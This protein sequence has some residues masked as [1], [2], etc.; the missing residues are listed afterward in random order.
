M[1]TLFKYV[2]KE[3]ILPFFIGLVGFIIFVSVELLY[4]LSDVIVQNHVSFWSLLVLVYYNLPQ[5]VVMGI[6]VGVLLAIF[7]EISN[8]SSRRELM[9]FQVHGINLKKFVL[10]FLVIGIALSFGTYL[11]QDF[12]VPNYNSKAS[13]YLA[14]TVWHSGLPQV[15]TNT[16][17]K[18][19]NS[20]FYVKA[21]DPNTE[22]FEGVLIYKVAGNSYTVTYAK[23]AYLQKGNWFLKDGRIYTLKNGVMT[24]DM[25]FKTMKLKMTQDIVRFIRSQK[26]AQSMSSK[27]LRERIKLFKRLG[28]DPRIYVV[29]L[30]SR[31]ANSIAPLI[32]AFL[33]VPF[34]LFF[35][36][37][38]KSWGVIV[39]F[40]LVVLYQG[41]GAW[42]SAM[43]KNGMFPPAMSAWTPDIIFASLGAAFFL[44]LDSK[45]MFKVK[46]TIVKLLPVF[47][48]F[49][50]VGL[51][52]NGFG[53]QFS[54]SAKELNIV[55]STEVIYSGNVEVKGSG[56]TIE[57]STLKILFDRYGRAKWAI[58]EGDVVF[59][60]KKKKITATR[61][62][63]QLQGYTAILDDIRGVEKVKNAKG[64]KKDVYFYGEHSVYDTKSG[65]SIITPG[66]I[67][68][69]NF[70]P[71]H[72]KI[73]ASK[74]YF[75]PGDHMV[76]YNVVMY[77]F[78]VPIFYLPEYYYSLAG[79]KQPMEI[80][81]NHSASEG[82]Y[83]SVRFNFSPSPNLNA[84]VFFS[85]YEKGPS[86]QS[87]GLNAKIK[88]I[89]FAFSY[90]KTEENGKISS[91]NLKLSASGKFFGY[92]S[93][94]SY[95]ENVLG[96]TRNAALALNGPLAN[97]AL[98]LKI[99]QSVAGNNQKYELPYSLKGLR[100][101]LGK[102]TANSVISGN[103]IF[104]LPSKDFSVANS[105][106][107]K[108]SFP[109]RFLTL[110]SVSGTYKGGLSFSSNAPFS[111]SVFTDAGYAFDS[112]GFN[113]LGAKFGFSYSAKTGFKKDSNS[114]ELS[115]RIAAILKSSFSDDIFG[116]KVSAIHTLIGVGGE[117]VSAF[118]THSFENK[119]DFSLSY[120]FPF[121][122]LNAN[123]KFSY[124][125]NNFSNPWSNIALNTSSGFHIL[126]TSN[127]LKTTTIIYPSFKPV[128]T[129]FT[130]V[131]KWKGV[132]YS[133]NTLYDYSSKNLSDIS[134]KLEASLGNF[135]FFSK[136]KF[137]SNFV[138]S[139]KT[140]SLSAMN[141]KAS[142]NIPPLDLGISSNGSFSNG[143][144][145]SLNL[146]F[147]K[148]LRCLG[149]KGSISL[150]PS[151]GFKLS[152]MSLTLYITAFPEKYV[153]VDPVKG[154][155]GFSFF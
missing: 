60:E 81:I 120:A 39:T 1:K 31:F 97:G 46:E 20:Y 113:L 96:N 73:E 135:L 72:Y 145:Q 74:I 119:V 66:Y 116:F 154:S 80:S 26:T 65:T 103:G 38:S 106:S 153:S 86:S 70:I 146:S 36:I 126:G 76:A 129:K 71:P 45:V 24:F 93:A 132:T 75:V 6:P 150:S 87:F 149:F 4:Q 84:N 50:I 92:N 137:S 3:F 152:D 133:A 121:V 11:I 118:D 102:F 142:G 29:E 55:S 63:V 94:F 58:F 85:S 131:S 114:A 78:G 136:F 108:F 147:S 13:E 52:F 56:Y 64:V 67:T 155:F 10:P 34:S 16:F 15:K 14:K 47:V 101:N 21:F 7:W 77:I 32:I 42:L 49:F 138:I 130:F 48:M 40:V 37:K 88:N 5:F 91:E 51:S 112:F 57:A 33:G 89:P 69:C 143:E 22:R 83:S 79:G 148:G 98:A 68:T 128:N 41:S 95:S 115:D 9:A 100:M 35:G 139:S 110:K 104:S 27:E 54:V 62:E 117:N 2:S 140:F 125:F 123:A 59:Q 23:D 61:L 44:L 109:F 43:G 134:N 25:S 99:L 53:A 28:L 90:S 144:F 107:G 141:F 127:T 111:Y 122:P 18:A 8:F 30:N 17:F 124:D 151:E 82:W 19:G 105:L 12:V